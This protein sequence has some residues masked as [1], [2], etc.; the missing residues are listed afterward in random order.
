MSKYFWNQDTVLQTAV[1][2][3]LIPFKTSTIKK[4]NEREKEKKWI[5]SIGKDVEKLESLFIAGR[6]VR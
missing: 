5:G 4:K 2:C 6:N 3:H 1:K